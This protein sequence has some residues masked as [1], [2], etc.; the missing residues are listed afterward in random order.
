VDDSLGAVTYRAGVSTSPLVRSILDTARRPPGW[1]RRPW[2][3][4]LALVGGFGVFAALVTVQAARAGSGRRPLD[5]LAWSLLALAMVALAFRRQ[6]PALVVLA[7]S[8]ATVASVGLGY[9]LGLIWV[10]PLLALYTAAAIGHRRLAVAAGLAMAALLV[11]WALADPALGTPAEVAMAVLNVAL[12]VA[13]GEVARGRRDY[14]AEA[15]R[16]AVEAERTREETARRRAGEERL[17]LAR[18]LH[19]IT[20]NTIAVIAIQAGVAEEA[21]QDGP[22]PA[23]EAVRAIRASSRQALAELKATVATLREGEATTARGPLPSLDR[24]DELVAQARGVGI[25][26]ELTVAG[27]AR[28]LPPAVE[29]TAYRIVQEALT[30]VLRHAQATSAAI[31]VRYQGDA[32]EVEVD[33]DGRGGQPAAASRASGGGVPAGGHPGHGLTVMAERAA[34]VGGRLEAGPRPTGGFR[35]H[36]RLP[37]GQGAP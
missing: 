28:P 5:W 25:Q 3:A 31:C 11:G 17:R 32:L 12:A 36:A 16:R 13:T 1:L 34:A 21:L 24:L 22:E 2:A 14:L 6:R 7:T 26:V 27:T 37:L 15:E 20:A 10:T 35:V 18:D 19:D 33:D 4:D 30:N 29:V 8:A 9:P 23:R